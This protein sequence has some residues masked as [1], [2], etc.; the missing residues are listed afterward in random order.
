MA[1]W[2]SGV[3]LQARQAAPG[4][5]RRIMDWYDNGQVRP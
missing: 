2:L 5:L 3:L 4:Y 1:T